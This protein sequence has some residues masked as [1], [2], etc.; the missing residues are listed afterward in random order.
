MCAANDRHQ[1]HHHE[2]HHAI[3]ATRAEALGKTLVWAMVLNMVYV[4]AEA[5]Y[6]IIYDSMGLV[7]DAG[8]NLSD[9]ASLLISFI[10][11]RASRRKPDARH[12]Y[13]YARLTI[14][15]SL[16]NAII[17]Y[18]AVF[19]ILYQSVAKIINPPTDIDGNT[20]AIVAGIGVVVNGITARMLM[21]HAHDDLNAKGS[22]LHMVADTLV[23]VGVVIAGIVITYTGA[24]IIDPIIAIVIA[25]IIAITSFSLL[26]DSSHLAINGVPKNIDPDKVADAILSLPTVKSMHHMHIWPISTTTAALTVHVIC[27]SPTLID[28]TIADVRHAVEPLGITHSTI[29]AETTTHECQETPLT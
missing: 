1:E 6:G 26:R 13:G 4:F 5:A 14:D 25:M 19:A 9:V 21:S 3:S 8:H 24:T 7:S 20:I 17:L 23:S 16:V 15:A 29:E 18:G 22:Y 11:L 2:H 10:A 27:E 12:T 28:K